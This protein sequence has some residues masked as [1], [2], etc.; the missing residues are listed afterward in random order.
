[1]QTPESQAA[2]VPVLIPV[3][4]AVLAWSRAQDHRGHDKHDGLNSP[5]LRG[6]LGRGRWPR[7]VAIQSVMRLPFNVRPLLG[8]PRVHNPKGLS[9]FVR[10]HLNL[11]LAG[12]CGEHLA[13]AGRLLSLLDELRSPG[14]WRGACWGYRYDWQDAGFFAPSGTPNAVVTSFVCEALLDAYRVTRRQQYLET[15]ASAAGYFLRDLRVLKDSGDELCLGY[16]TVPMTVRV[17]DVSALIASVLAQHAALSGDRR[18]AGDAR[19]L[20]NYVAR[21]QTTYG[22]WW[23]TDPPADSHIRHDNYHTGFILDAMQRYMDAT[24][25]RSFQDNYDAGLRFYAEKLFNADGSPRWMSDVD[26]PHDIHGAAQ[27][28]LTFSRH[29]AEWPGLAARIAGWSL[30]RMYDPEGRFYYQETRWGRKRFTLLRWCNAWMSLGL[31]ALVLRMGE[32][33]R[34]LDA[35]RSA[36]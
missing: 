7:L 18:H 17:M 2:T 32:Q 14:S 13:E 29:L 30:A 19:R 33:S 1:M 11:H 9:L 16:T 4:D 12:A 36:P 25:D 31:S 15:V 34:V 5:L 27:G 26:Y 21:R 28:I 20:M 23:Y 24:G 3:L 35:Q 10:A 8:I 22:A 6:L